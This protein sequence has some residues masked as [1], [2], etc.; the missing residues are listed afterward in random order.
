SRRSPPAT[1]WPRSRSGIDRS[2]RAGA[3]ATTRAHPRRLPQWR[4]RQ[5]CRRLAASVGDG[6]SVRWAAPLHSARAM[7]A[8]AASMQNL[9][10]TRRE[11]SVRAH[12]D[13]Q[14]LAQSLFCYSPDPTVR[15]I[16]FRRI[17]YIK[18]RR[19]LL[20]LPWQGRTRYVSRRRPDWII[21][22]NRQVPD[23][24]FRFGDNWLDFARSL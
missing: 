13:A 12:T 3:G 7:A 24:R 16:A 11:Q 23:R 10:Q 14:W 20:H 21:M 15:T 19:S 5:R 8:G 1:R 2:G 4:S 17:A 6:M 9:G 18:A 22:S